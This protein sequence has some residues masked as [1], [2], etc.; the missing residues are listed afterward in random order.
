[1]NVQGE[2]EEER[3]GEGREGEGER[4]EGEGKE[5]IFLDTNFL[6]K[7]DEASI[8]SKSKSS[9]SLFSSS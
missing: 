4:G 5:G 9:L 3:E 6:L 8:V 2:R 1:M 7:Y